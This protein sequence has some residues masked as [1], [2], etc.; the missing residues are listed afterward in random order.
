MAKPCGVCTHKDVD[1][2]NQNTIAQIPLR[3]IA[4]SSDPHVSIGALH[5][6]KDHIRELIAEQRAGVRAERGM[7]LISRVE[8]IIEEAEAILK[9]AK[10]SKDLRCAI[11]ALSAIG[12]Q[13]ELIGKL[14]GGL[15]QVGGLTVN[16]TTHN[17]TITNYNDDSEIAIL[18]SEATRGFD[19]S[20]IERLKALAACTTHAALD[21]TTTK[22]T[23]KN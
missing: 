18:V 5:R 7:N 8:K 13:L 3:A 22:Q 23:P 9:A 6:H 4:A 12:K 19:P 11:L 1:R 17:T 2:I 20:E 14:S 21:V 15:S 16:L 10:S